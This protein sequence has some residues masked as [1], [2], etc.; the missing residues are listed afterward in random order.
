M[1]F[2]Q[3][4]RSGFKEKSSDLRKV[5][6]VSGCMFLLLT[7]E[8][9]NLWANS[10]MNPSQQVIKLSSK[11]QDVTVQEVLASVEQQTDYHF[12][13][14][15]MQIGADRRVT[16]DLNNKSVTEILDEL[17]LGKK[18]QYVVEGNNIVLFADNKKAEVKDIVQQKSKIVT[19]TVLDVTGMP[20][21]GANVTVKGTTQ[22]T[23]TD[24]DGKFSLEV[25]EGD[26]LQ[27]TYIGFANQEVKVGTQTNLSVTL[28]E[29]AEALDEL[30]VVGYGTQKKVNLTGAVASISSEEIQSRPITNVT[31][32]LQGITPGL[33]ITA[34]NTYGGEVGSPMDMNIRGIGSL[35]EGSGKPYV[36]V[37]GVPMDLALVNPNDIENISVLKDAASAAIYG[38]RAAYG[39][40]L[41]TTK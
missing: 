12:T 27:V 31:Q 8:G 15:P 11:M 9:S 34:S 2:K 36:L 14:N 38:A 17:F 20:V 23:I 29:D 25:A 30:V 21:I 19:G 28:K 35:T 6:T 32:A 33:N 5:I 10:F 1:N 7:V 26:I 18:V 22:G 39:V 3:R 16:I 41:V 37:D 24:M 40:I 13:Y 4:S